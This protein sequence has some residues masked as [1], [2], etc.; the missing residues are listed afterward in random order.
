MS[1]IQLREGT[2]TDWAIDLLFR[3]LIA[4]LMK[5]PYE[6]RVATMGWITRKILAPAAG[7][8]HRADANLTLIYPDMPP[9][10]RKAIARACCDNFGRTIIENY[11]W[12]ELGERMAQVTP[13]GAGLSALQEAAAAKR[14]VI[15]ATGHFGNHE[16]ARHLLT[17]QG[18]TVGGFYR[19]MNNPFFNTHY[20]ATMSSWGGPVFAKGRQ[21]TLGFVRHLHKGGMGTIFIDVAARGK[22][23]PFL[24]QPARTS[25]SP[26]EIAL[27]LDAVIIPYFAI[28][29]PDGL[30]FAVEVEAP[31]T[32]ATPKKMMLEMNQRL[33]AQIT[34][35]PAQWFWVHRRWKK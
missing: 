16:A 1:K 31:I 25:L 19:P 27:K 12:P 4:G 10:E 30:T 9:Q 22:V 32:H 35:N 26:A 11:S 18:Y 8:L 3:G 7:Y 6:R 15:F 24:G 2:R 13:T 29:Q 20:V 21:G 33:E 34:R 17:A 28:R 23:L 5:L 14:P